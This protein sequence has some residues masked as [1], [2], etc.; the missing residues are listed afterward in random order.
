[1]DKS[2]NI[3]RDKLLAQLLC[4]G[5]N[6]ALSELM[7]LY[8]DAIFFT[9]FKMVNN[10]A[11]A[12]DLSIEVFQK[13]FLNIQSYSSEYAFSTWL[14]KIASNTCI[15][16]LRKKKANFISIDD[17]KDDQTETI[18]P[19]AHHD[20]GPDDLLINKQAADHLRALVE[21]LK[22]FWQRLIEMR[23][24]KELSY[25]EIADQLQ[26][27]MGTIKNQLYRAKEQLGKLYSNNKK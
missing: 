8:Y 3:K 22:P 5:E 20:P 16:F 15:D 11:D 24:Y 4:N 14:F 1:M 27:P 19:I 2:N 7:D 18:T 26:V 9:I 13:V 17:Q 10:R 25:E 23:Y 6:S 21:Q 12:E